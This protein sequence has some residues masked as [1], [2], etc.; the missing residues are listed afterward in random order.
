MAPQKDKNM[1]K[2]FLLIGKSHLGHDTWHGTFEILE[3]AENQVS[4]IREDNGTV[5]ECWINGKSFDKYEIIDLRKWVCFA[6]G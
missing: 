4:N 6:K 3:I 1:H 5:F 2:W